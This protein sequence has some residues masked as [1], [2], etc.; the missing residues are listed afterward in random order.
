MADP[1]RI[2][3]RA[4]GGAAGAPSAL[5]NAEPA[6][7]E[8]DDTLYYGKG[9]D[10]SGNATSIIPIA[11]KGGFVDKTT[12]QTIAGIKTFS[13]S[14][15]APTPTGGD[16]STKVATTAFVA[17][18]V[19]GGSVADGD[20]GDVVVSGSGATWTIDADA[21]GNTKLANMATK[22]YKGRTSGSTGDPEDV[23][24]ATLKTDLA[25]VKGDVG[26]G[27]VDNTA[28]SA[29][30]VS[31]AQQTALDLKANLAS[32]A[33]TGTPTAP[34]ASAG[35][36][37]TQL[38]TAAFVIAEILARLASNDALLYKGAIDASS[39]PNYPAADAGHTY[40]ISVAGKIGGASG[41]NVQVGDRITANVDGL[42][43]GN[44]AT[45]GGSWDIIQANIDGAVILDAAQTLTNKTMSGASNTF[46][47]IP[48]SA[49]T[50]LGTMSTQNASAVAIT[51]GTIDGVTL[52]GGTF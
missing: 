50:G 24:V 17:G 8:Q 49:I 33:L 35:T 31:T 37:T 19:T 7:N 30:P 51:G 44:H 10:G 14:P 41:V 1:I 40:R 2:K 43:A 46:S 16:S 25:L 34:T 28:D 42:S 32:P 38:A 52:D 13:S 22:T 21:V 4:S 20:K 15:I 36:N 39:N 3:R 6:Y 45:V 48:N 12:D 47:N 5:K 26:L 18:A 11:G 27:N 23:A 29:K 9:D